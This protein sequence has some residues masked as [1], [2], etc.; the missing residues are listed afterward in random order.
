MSKT[1]KTTLD[2]VPVEME[3]VSIG[4]SSRMKI[5]NMKG[6]L[7]REIVI[8]AQTHQP[9]TTKDTGKPQEPKETINMNQEKEESQ[10]VKEFVSGQE[11]KIVQEIEQIGQE[12]QNATD[13]KPWWTSRIIIANLAFI[14]SGLAATFGFNIAISEEYITIIGAI[15]GVINIYL[16]KTTTQ[17]ISSKAL[18]DYMRFNK[19]P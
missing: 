5:D 10:E 8:N 18:P 7:A 16:R 4:P 12:I 9:Q 3:L 19:N 17:S 11:T 1:I 15:M 2:G 6:N 14:I 13:E